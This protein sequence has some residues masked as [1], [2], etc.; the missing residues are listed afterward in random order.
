MSVYFFL[1]RDM[2]G[3]VWVG[4]GGGGGMQVEFSSGEDREEESSICPVRENY[5]R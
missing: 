3:F 1:S 5:L 2:F 4:W